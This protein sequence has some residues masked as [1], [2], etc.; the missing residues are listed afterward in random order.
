MR[1]RGATPCCLH[2]GPS[3]ASL[4][5]LHHKSFCVPSRKP[6]IQLLN[7]VHWKKDRNGVWERVKGWMKV[8]V[9]NEEAVLGLRVRVRAHICGVLHRRLISSTSRSFILWLTFLCHPDVNEDSRKPPCEKRRRMLEQKGSSPVCVSRF[10]IGFT[11][12]MRTKYQ[13]TQARNM[14]WM[15]GDML[16]VLKSLPTLKPLKNIPGFLKKNLIILL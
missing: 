8:W 4:V 1:G 9:W 14:N 11:S 3:E 16:N 13:R 15:Y 7:R 2:P 5:L 10:H 6:E 12:L